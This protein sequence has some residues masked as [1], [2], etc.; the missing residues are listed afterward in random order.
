M[1]TVVVITVAAVLIELRRQGGSW[2]FGLVMLGA[3][4]GMCYLLNADVGLGG[5]GALTLVAV[6]RARAAWDLYNAAPRLTIPYL[7]MPDPCSSLLLRNRAGVWEQYWGWPP[8]VNRWLCLEILPMNENKLFGNAWQQLI[9]GL[10]CARLSR[11]DEIYVTP[12]FLLIN[13][14]IVTTE[15]VKIFVGPAPSGRCVSAYFHFGESQFGVGHRRNWTL[16]ETVLPGLNRML[17][18][19]T[20]ANDTLVMWVRAGDAF[21]GDAWPDDSDVVK[22]YGQPP[23]SYYLDVMKWAG[24]GKVEVVASDDKNP[25]VVV[26]QKR[27]AV[28]ERRSMRDD[29]RQLLAAKN[30]LIGRGTFGIAVAMLSERVENL[31][32]A[33]M[34][35]TRFGRPHW[36]CRVP[37]SYRAASLSENWA[38]SPEQL[39]LMMDESVKSLG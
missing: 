14:R 21:S 12:G 39:A 2:V 4:G 8:I 17:E 25:V 19:P 3:A 7:A 22:Y 6:V 28:W 24:W 20:I 36:N 34:P 1:K 31:W 13:E 11:V 27:G 29:I 9:T 5:F 38:H 18:V 37:D 10:E 26:L 23:V 35:S 30:L 15:G 33:E 32:T 16:T